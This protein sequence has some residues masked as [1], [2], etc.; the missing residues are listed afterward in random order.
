[1]TTR[2]IEQEKRVVDAR[3]SLMQAISDS[4]ERDISIWI[5]ALAECLKRVSDWNLKAEID[6]ELEAAAEE[7][8]RDA[9]EDR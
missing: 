9:W 1:M 4:E 3:I 2:E 8:A 6:A 5:A 7:A